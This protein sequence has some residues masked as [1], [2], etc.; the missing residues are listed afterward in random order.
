MKRLF[1]ALAAALLL[2]SC[3]K[4][5]ATGKTEIT[6]QRFF[7][8]CADEYG[9]STDVARADG[10]CGIITTLVNRFQTENPDIHV[11]VQ[12]VFWPG[13]DQ[14]TAQLAANDAPDLVTMHASVIPDYRSRGLLEPIGDELR[15][16]GVEQARFSGAARHAVLFGGKVYGLPFDTWAPLWHINLTLFQKA[17][18]VR[19]GKAILPTNEQQLIAEAQQ[20]KRATGKPF[21]VQI[22][23]NEYAAFTRNL[24]TGLIQQG[25]TIFSDDRHIRLTTPEAH[26][27]LALY[28]NI[29][30]LGLTTKNLDYSAATACYLNGCGGVFLTGTWMVGTFDKESKTPGRPLSGGYEVVP[31]PN[32]FGAREAWFIDGHNWVVPVNR[33]RTAGQRKATFRLMRFLAD[34]DG[35]WARTGHLPAYTNVLG[36]SQFR[37]LPHRSSYME[38]ASKGVPLPSTIRRQYPIETIVGEETAAA[39]SGQKSI[40]RALS[41]AQARINDLLANI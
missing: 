34:H 10:E 29:Y 9:H 5:A 27:V 14:L 37:A 35:D 28:K 7:G 25:T 8:D 36:S 4:P 13:Y 21:F 40:D 26:R 33:H 22:M 39:I 12:T 1:L 3:S 24:Y 30:D 6:L 38:L 20:F 16:V 2:G 15:A 32:V 17:G 41:D 23:A 18:L 19:D 11:R 31:Y